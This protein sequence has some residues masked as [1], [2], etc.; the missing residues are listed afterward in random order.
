VKNIN[1]QT[2]PKKLGEAFAQFGEIAGARIITDIV[3]GQRVSAGFGFV[4][5][6]TQEAFQKAVDNQIP[7]EV[8]GQE[9][10]VR[11]ARV[12]K[13]FDTTNGGDISLAS[14]ESLLESRIDQAIADT[15]PSDV[16]RIDRLKGMKMIAS[17][18]ERVASFSEYLINYSACLAKELAKL[19]KEFSK[20]EQ[21]VQKA[22]QS[23][24]LS[25]SL[26]PSELRKGWPLGADDSIQ[27]EYQDALKLLGTSKGGLVTAIENLVQKNSELQGHQNR[28]RPRLSR[29]KSKIDNLERELELRAS[30][31]EESIEGGNVRATIRARIQHISAQLNELSEDLGSRSKPVTSVLESDY[32]V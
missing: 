2:E 31:H 26:W 20:L 14:L 22:K 21:K 27:R 9:L 15:L 18:P 30:N 1:Y 3:G 13:R 28:N 16:A 19:R 4:D 24:S 7:L 10:R 32:F 29:Q 25:S 8:D 12:R 6:K 5:F 11:P 17:Y 23:S